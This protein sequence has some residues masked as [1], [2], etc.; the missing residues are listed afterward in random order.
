MHSDSGKSNTTSFLDNSL[1]ISPSV[2]IPINTLSASTIQAA[3]SENCVISNTAS[4]SVCVALRQAILSC[5]CITSPTVRSK[6][7]PN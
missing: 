1:R 2:T 5:L 6:L 4:F 7:R 3:P